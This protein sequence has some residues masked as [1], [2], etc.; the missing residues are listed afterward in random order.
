MKPKSSTPKTITIP[1]DLS[2]EAAMAL[3]DLLSEIT[4]TVW[5]HY[6]PQLVTLI[7]NDLF[8][9]TNKPVDFDDE[10]PF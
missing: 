10:I 7:L 3:Y 8:P 2:P 4:E 1:D 9:L 6:Q 5:E